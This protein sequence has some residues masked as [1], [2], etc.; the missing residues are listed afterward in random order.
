MR[1]PVVLRLDS[2]YLVGTQRR[3]EWRTVSVWD[4]AGDSKVLRSSVEFAGWRVVGRDSIAVRLEAFPIVMQP[5]FA[6]RQSVTRGRALV[7]WD[8]PGTQLAEVQL[9][10]ATCPFH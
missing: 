10:R 4:S 7:G 2:T 9:K 8:T 6:A 5:R 1:L 3:G